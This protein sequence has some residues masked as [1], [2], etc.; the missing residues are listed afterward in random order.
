MIVSPT[1]TATP[2]PARTTEF[3][4]G[5]NK[6]RTLKPDNTSN[7]RNEC[8]LI[9]LPLSPWRLE[10]DKLPERWFDPDIKTFFYL[11]Y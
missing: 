8:T 5:S 6:L 1:F 10:N 2:T 4:P 3:A 7:W 9:S 11:G